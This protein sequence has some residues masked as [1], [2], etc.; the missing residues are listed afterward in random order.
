MFSEH[1]V[2]VLCHKSD[3]DIPLLE[4]LL[5]L[6]IFGMKSQ[7]LNIKLALYFYIVWSL[8]TYLILYHFP[9][10]TVLEI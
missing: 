6:T 8:L 4:T 9:R 5:L 7:L 2:T 3:L 1:H 10:T